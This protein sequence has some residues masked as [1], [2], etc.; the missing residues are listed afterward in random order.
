MIWILPKHL[1]QLLSNTIINLS[2]INSQ[3]TTLKVLHMMQN[4]KQAESP[5]NDYSGYNRIS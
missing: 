3:T 2:L 1:I 4:S 5:Q